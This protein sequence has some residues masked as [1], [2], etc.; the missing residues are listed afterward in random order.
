MTIRATRAMKYNLL[1]QCALRLI[2]TVAE[3][4]STV[5]LQRYQDSQA[6]TFGIKIDFP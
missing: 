4:S 6:S 2:C 5:A 1:E 3:V